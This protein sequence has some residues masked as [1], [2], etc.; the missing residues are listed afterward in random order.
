MEQRHGQYSDFSLPGTFMSYNNI[1]S[2]LQVRCKCMNIV[3]KIQYAAGQRA[4]RVYI[5][6]KRSP[7]T[8]FQIPW[9]VCV[10][11]AD[12]FE[13]GSV[14]GSDRAHEVRSLLDSALHAAWIFRT[15][16]QVCGTYPRNLLTCLLAQSVWVMLRHELGHDADLVGGKLYK[17]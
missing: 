9:T 3:F 10:H 4:C 11:G 12:D 14:V 13:Q 7:S 16:L 15:T 5:H 6:K 8:T 2:V 17:Y 1:S